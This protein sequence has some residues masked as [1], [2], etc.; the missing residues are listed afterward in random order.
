MARGL[1]TAR[2]TAMLR[3]TTI[4]DVAREAGVSKSTVSRVLNDSPNVAAETRAQVL[5]AVSRLDFRANAA[6]RGLRTT[7]SSLVG[8]LLPAIDNDVFSRVAEVIEEDLRR[9][10][11]GLVIVSSG[12]NVAGERLALESLRATPGRRPGAL[13]GQRPRPPSRRSARLDHEADRADRPRDRRDH[14]RDTAL[15]DLRS[16]VRDAVEHLAELGHRSVG[17]ATISLDV[18]PGREVRSRVRGDRGATSGSRPPSSIVVPYDRIDR[19]SGWEIAERDARGR[20]DRDPLL[21]PEHRHRRRTRTSRPAGHRD[22]R[23]RLDHR[24]RRERA[25]LGQEAPAHRDLPADRRSRALR[26]PDGHLEARR[27]RPATS[28][29]DGLR[30]ASGCGTRPPRPPCL[31]CR[32]RREARVSGAGGRDRPGLDP[33]PIRDVT[34]LRL[35]G[36]AAATAGRRAGGRH[37]PHLCRRQDPHAERPGRDRLRVRPRPSRRRDHRERA[38]TAPARRRFRRGPSSFAPSSPGRTGPTPSAGCSRSRRAPSTSR[39]GTC[40]AGA[41]ALRSPTCSAGAVRR[42]RS[43]PSAATSARATTDSTVSRTRW[44]GSCGS[45]CRAVKVTIGADE[46]AVDVRRLAAV[47]EV[48]GPDCVLVADAFR[49]FTSLDD[50]LRR[51]RRPSG[52]RPRLPRGPVLGEPGAARRRSAAPLRAADR[53]G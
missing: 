42:S 15:T 7:R 28:R 31:A 3:E 30:R 32:P 4:L 35:L 22:S 44:P 10:H 36:S 13:A 40:S 49:S 18:R 21:R 11:V 26:E 24:L 48:V 16:G 23:G 20:R 41:P 43:A 6:A 38:R 37:P 12:W 2:L 45:G 53:A 29:Q 1:R 8:L 46:P 51:L 14:G 25:R 39:S 17:I 50:A 27:P 47:R 52:V 9:V 33:D 19:R 5:E 34:L